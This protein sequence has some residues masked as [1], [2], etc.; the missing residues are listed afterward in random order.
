MASRSC[1][2]SE[3]G[4]QHAKRPAPKPGPR[5]TT[6][7][8]EVLKERREKARAKRIHDTYGLTEEDFLAV[9]EA[10]DWKCAICKKPFVRKNGSVDHCH[11]TEKLEGRELQC[12]GSF[13]GGRTPSSGVWATARSI[14]RR[15]PST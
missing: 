2:N 6:C 1:K 11:K 13:T 12:E 5:C 3:P 15:W 4:T 7:H 10:Q 8:R 14:S 9:M